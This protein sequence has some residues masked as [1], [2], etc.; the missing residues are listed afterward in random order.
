M[1]NTGFRQTDH[2]HLAWARNLDPD[3]QTVRCESVIKPGLTYDLKYDAL[4]IGVGA[5]SNTLGVP[6]VEEN[7][8]FLKV[9]SVF[10]Q[11]S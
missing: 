3:A 5:L 1:R 4:V 2:F 11:K 8:F 10:S 6:G 7:A 9:R